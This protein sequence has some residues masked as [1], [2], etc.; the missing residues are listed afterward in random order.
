VHAMIPFNRDMNP[1]MLPYNASERSIRYYNGMITNI[2]EASYLSW[3]RLPKMVKQAIPDTFVNMCLWTMVNDYLVLKYLN[4][5]TQ[6]LITDVIADNKGNMADINTIRRMDDDKDWLTRKIEPLSRDRRYLI[7]EYNQQRERNFKFK[8]DQMAEARGSFGNQFGT[9]SSASEFLLYEQAFT[10]FRVSMD[11]A[12]QMNDLEVA[13]VLL[14][15]YPQTDAI[16][17]EVLDF[18]VQYVHANGAYLNMFT[19]LELLAASQNFSFVMPTANT[20]REDLALEKR[21]VLSPVTDVLSVYNRI[22]KK[23]SMP[24]Q[25]LRVLGVGSV[26]NKTQDYFKARKLRQL[27]AT[28]VTEKSKIAAGE[29]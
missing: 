3:V 25:F 29:S 15:H 8:C 7:M 14:H 16:T 5:S 26:V 24:A 19:P 13:Q 20:T 9:V 12:Y 10:I 4:S 1:A 28:K 27:E 18:F 23:E 17:P 6:E 22:D 11:L 21:L 2:Q